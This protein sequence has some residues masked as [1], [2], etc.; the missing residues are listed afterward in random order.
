MC[1]CERVAQAERTKETL[2]SIVNAG[3]NA[4]AKHLGGYGEN[5]VYLTPRMYAALTIAIE[6][7]E[8]KQTTGT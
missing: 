5:M 3:R 7:F 2:Q 1:T 4:V 6:R 8:N